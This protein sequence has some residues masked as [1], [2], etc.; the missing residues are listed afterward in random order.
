MPI[1][2]LSVLCAQLTRYLFA[3]AKFLLPAGLRVVQPCRYCF[4][5]PVLTFTFIGAKMWEYSPQNCQNFEFWPEICTSGVTR[6]KYF[7]EILSIVRVYR[8]L[9]SFSFG[10]F[11]ETNTQVISIFPRWGH[12]PTNFQQPIAAKLL[13]GSKKLGVQ[14]WDGPPLLPCQVWWGSWV[15]RRLQTK[16]CDVFLSVCLFFVTL[17][18]DEVCDNGN[19]MKQYNFQNN[20]G[21][22]AQRKVSSCAPIFKFLYGPPDFFLGA[23]LYQK[24]LFLAILAAVR[25]HFKAAKAKV[26]VVVGTQESLPHAKFCK[27]CLRGYT[28]NFC[29]FGG[30]KPTNFEATAVK[31]GV[32]VQTWETLPQPKFCENRLRVYPPF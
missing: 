10:H 3:I 27:N 25:P 32:R 16:K 31:F 21:T 29:D 23:H 30:C 14:K 18:N 17:W 8:Q 5:S 12:F 15:A 28:P 19:D 9:L 22:V 2:A 1:D 24:L 7:Y 26:S 4:Y 20:Y 6:L 13:I 11:R